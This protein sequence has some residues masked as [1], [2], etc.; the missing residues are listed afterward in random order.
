[1]YIYIY[2]YIYILL[3]R[4]LQWSYCSALHPVFMYFCILVCLFIAILFSILCDCPT[5]HS[6]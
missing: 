5:V 3:Q 2:I 4:M 1:M 6:S